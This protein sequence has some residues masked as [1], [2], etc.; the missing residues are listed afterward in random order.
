MK[1]F[2]LGGVW[3]VFGGESTEQQ[4]FCGSRLFA[5]IV[6]LFRPRLPAL[7]PFP[8]GL[9]FVNWM[10]MELRVVATPCM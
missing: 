1:C 4:F 8:S 7:Q 9:F 5:R 6:A 3:A 10:L 2:N